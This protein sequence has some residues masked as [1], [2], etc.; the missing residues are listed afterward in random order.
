MGAACRRR[1]SEVTELAAAFDPRLTRLCGLL[2]REGRRLELSSTALSVLGQLR[3][4]P[5]RITELAATEQITQPSMTALVNRLQERGWVARAD[6]PADGRTVLV[7]LSE[8]GAL[9][10]AQR[11]R[12]RVETLGERLQV[13]T[14][15]QR[16]AVAAALPALDALI[17]RWETP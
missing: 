1:S 5:R 4:G 13:L 17:D 15:E 6:D 7:T 8:Q 11:T 10:L 12:Q 2:W 3:C 16:A 14:P 9:A